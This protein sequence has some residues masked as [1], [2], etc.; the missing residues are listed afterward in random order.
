M[1]ADQGSPQ[2]QPF[3]IGRHTSINIP[4]NYQDANESLVTALQWPRKVLNKSFA[5]IPAH[6]GIQ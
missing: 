3:L 4:G 6:A 5:V 1:G 2:A